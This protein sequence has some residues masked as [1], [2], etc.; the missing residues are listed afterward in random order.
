MGTRGGA[1]GSA[2]LLK[3]LAVLPGP[4]RPAL[5]LLAPVQPLRI[6]RRCCEARAEGR[7]R[8]R[9]YGRVVPGAGVE[10][11]QSR[12]RGVRARPLACRSTAGL[13]VEH[14]RG[15][16]PGTEVV[17]A[18]ICLRAVRGALGQSE[19][20]PH[21]CR[22]ST[23]PAAGHRFSRPRQGASGQPERIAPPAADRTRCRRA[24]RQEVQSLRGRPGRQ[25]DSALRRW[26]HDDG[27]RAHRCGWRQ[28]ARAFAVA[29][30]GAACGDRARDRYREACSE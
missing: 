13:P 29:A 30:A 27:G 7:H 28:L 14:Q 19:P 2:R 5:S 23:A 8:R 21:F 17:S 18:G 16:Q 6:C 9:G 15:R 25:G 22:P 3:M 24:S 10:G 4:T 20:R 26:L 11:A 12:D 1:A